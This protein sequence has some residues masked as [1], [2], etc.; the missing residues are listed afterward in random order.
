MD[1]SHRFTIFADY[2]QFVVMDQDCRADF[3]AIWT[4]AALERMLAVDECALCPGTLRNIEV[5]VELVILKEPPLV[6]VETYD[7]VA[8]G[9][10]AVPSG[11]VVVM[12]CTGYL[13]DAPRVSVAPGTYQALFLVSGADTITNEWEPAQDKY[14]V[15]LWPGGMREPKLVKHWKADA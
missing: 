2:F 10:L 11:I 12:G 14:S 5:E 8:E 3:S 9:S 13:P 1:V 4:G 15:Y 6:K 7:H